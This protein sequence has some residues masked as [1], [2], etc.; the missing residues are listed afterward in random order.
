MKTTRERILEILDTRQRMTTS[1]LARLTHVTPAD[2]RHHLRN[3]AGEGLVRRTGEALVEGRGR[4]APLYALAQPRGNL[5]GLAGHL[6]DAASP[7][8]SFPDSIARRFAPAEPD[9]TR[10]ITQRLVRAMGR[11]ADLEYQ[12]RWEAHPNGPQVILGR[13]PYREIIA[14]HPELCAIDAALLE[15]LL[16]QK[17]VQTDKLVRTSEGHF[18]CRF[19]IGGQR[20]E[21]KQ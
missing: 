4:P 8:P 6:L 20:G 10:H 19:S 14:E 13:C 17:A 12:P 11:L 9:L 7:D 3:L 21:L 15:R 18:V 5:A 1:E 16:G 2:I